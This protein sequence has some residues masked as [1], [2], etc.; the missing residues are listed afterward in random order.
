MNNCFAKKGGVLTRGLK[1][2][3]YES[4]LGSVF[5]LLTVIDGLRQM[6]T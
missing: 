5:K 2:A 1:N 4:C 3:T 6:T